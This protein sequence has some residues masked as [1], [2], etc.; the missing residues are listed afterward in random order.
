MQSKVRLLTASQGFANGVGQSVRAAPNRMQGEAIKP[1]GQS[2]LA[3]SRIGQE[4]KI[5]RRS[6]AVA[7]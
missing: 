7:Q 3:H 1:E 4:S 2:A 5:N 6:V